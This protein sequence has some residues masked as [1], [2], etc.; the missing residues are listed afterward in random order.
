[1][2]YVTPPN[3]PSDATALGMGRMS[4]IGDRA[5][6]QRD[7]SQAMAEM[8]RY[9]CH[10]EVWA[11]KIARR[12]AAHGSRRTRRATRSSMSPR[13]T[14]PSTLRTKAAITWSIRT[15]TSRTRRQLHSKKATPV[16]SCPQRE[17]FGF[18][19]AR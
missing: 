10:K 14:L 6:P 12:L 8:P 18:L 7:E 9:R 2:S 13:C 4:D 1:M 11:L 3:N 16:S 19:G 15:A 5:E 17:A